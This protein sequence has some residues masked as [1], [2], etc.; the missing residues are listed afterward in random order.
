MRKTDWLMLQQRLRQN[1]TSYNDAQKLR[2]SPH[3][4]RYFFLKRAFFLSV[5]ATPFEFSLV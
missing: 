3:I 4:S 5:E 1:C 2:L